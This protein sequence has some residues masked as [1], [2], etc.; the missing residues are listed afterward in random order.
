MSIALKFKTGVR[1]PLSTIGAKL[2]A[3]HVLMK[4]PYKILLKP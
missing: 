4:S 3:K 2:S 1:K